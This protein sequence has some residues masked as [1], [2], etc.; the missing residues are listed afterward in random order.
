[1]NLPPLIPASL[2]MNIY[3]G[4]SYSGEAWSLASV[5]RSLNLYFFHF[6]MGGRASERT[7]GRTDGRTDRRRTDG[8][9]DGRTG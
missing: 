2:G 7:V 8:W 1:M 4:T 3:L 6:N 5:Y 9:T